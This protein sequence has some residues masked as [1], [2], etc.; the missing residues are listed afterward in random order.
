MAD[1]GA[2]PKGREPPRTFRQDACRDFSDVRLRQSK[3]LLPRFP[4][5]LWSEP[6]DAKTAGKGERCVSLTRSAG[7]EGR[8]DTR[9]RHR[10]SKAAYRLGGSSVRGHFRTS[11]TATPSSS[12]LG[13]SRRVVGAKFCCKKWPDIRCRGEEQFEVYR[14]VGVHAVRRLLTGDDGFAK[15]AEPPEGFDAEVKRVLALLNVPLS[16]ATPP[17]VRIRPASG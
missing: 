15:P 6:V 2:G 12:L 13:A 4:K 11:R 3:P 10:F 8:G 14:A 7:R 5:L 16:M 9:L 1:A 17:A